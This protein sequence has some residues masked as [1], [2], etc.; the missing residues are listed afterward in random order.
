M[1]VVVFAADQRR[2]TVAHGKSARHRAPGIEIY[3]E[4]GKLIFYS[5]C[6]VLTVTINGRP[7]AS[8]PVP[9]SA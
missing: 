4:A 7:L 5:N 9:A 1:V 8:E 3:D 2:L 6:A